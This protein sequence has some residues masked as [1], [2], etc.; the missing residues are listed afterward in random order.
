MVW[1][2]FLI[3]PIFLFFTLSALC[4]TFICSQNK[5]LAVREKRSIY[6]KAGKELTALAR[7][8]CFIVSVLLISDYYFETSFIM[9]RLLQINFLLT[10]YLITT[11]SIFV[12]GILLFISLKTKDPASQI[13]IYLS[14]IFSIFLIYMLSIHTFAL[15]RSVIIPDSWHIYDFF[16][17]LLIQNTHSFEAFYGFPLIFTILFVFCIFLGFFS[18]HLL[19]IMFFIYRRNSDDY[20]RD[21]YNTLIT[22]HAKRSLFPGLIMCIILPLLILVTTLSQFDIINLVHFFYDATEQVNLSILNENA[23]FSYRNLAVVFTTGI[24]FIPLSVILLR[25]VANAQA[26]GT[27]PLQKKSLVFLSFITLILGLWFLLFRLIH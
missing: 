15:I 14:Q 26:K 4:L 24:C 22:S 12:V 25:P 23:T 8:I 5:R 2:T 19:S 13:F 6:A 1:G 21:Y 10:P 27:S 9:Q 16:Y 3:T 18:A 11:I 7:S 20:G 17:K